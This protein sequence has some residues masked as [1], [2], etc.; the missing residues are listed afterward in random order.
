VYNLKYSS[1]FKK[2]IKRIE[3]S[4]RK[5]SDIAEIKRIIYQLAI[6]EILPD[7]NKDHE[8]TGNYKNYRE[9]HIFPNL[10]LVYRYYEEDNDLMLYRIGSH[11]ELF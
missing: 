1:K 6:P 11:S 5:K 8:L 7:K 2:E 4:G 3:K 10:L 9:C